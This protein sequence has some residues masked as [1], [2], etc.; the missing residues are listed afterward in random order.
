MRYL[1]SFFV[2]ALICFAIKPFALAL[3]LSA[4]AGYIIGSL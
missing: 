3:A 1:F 4:I 2:G